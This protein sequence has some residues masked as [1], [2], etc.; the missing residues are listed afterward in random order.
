MRAAPPPQMTTDEFLAWAMARPEGE[1]Y[2]LV[3]GEVVAMSPERAGH[4]HRDTEDRP[5]AD[6]GCPPGRHP[7]RPAWNLGRGRGAVFVTKKRRPRDGRAG[8]AWARLTRRWLLLA[9][10]AATLLPRTGA[11]ARGEPFSD[12][13]WFADDGTGW[14]D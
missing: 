9:S 13:T 3:A 10:A 7:A 5:T 11:A 14:V 1:R 6:P 2:E 12:D 8:G 4:H